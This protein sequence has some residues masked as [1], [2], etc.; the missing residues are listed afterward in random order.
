MIQ[1]GLRFWREVKNDIRSSDFY[2]R[3][4]NIINVLR[5]VS[6]WW[7]PVYNF[8]NLEKDPVIRLDL[9]R[10]PR[11]FVR[12]GKSD[13]G[14]VREVFF[15]K[16]YGRAVS[17][18]HPGATILDVGAHIGVFSLFAARH[19][20]QSSIFAI[21]PIPENYVLLEKN[22]N[23]NGLSERVKTFRLALFGGGGRCPDFFDSRRYSRL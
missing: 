3:N 4:K 5:F 21:E 17:N 16:F 13:W 20:P 10:G 15:D 12:N 9:R 2:R 1:Y 14:I 11:L 22:I 8:L 6:N 18:L 23:I 19:I 7:L